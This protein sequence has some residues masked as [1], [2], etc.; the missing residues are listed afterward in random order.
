MLEVAKVFA[1]EAKPLR[2]VIFL[3]TTAHRAGLLG[4]RYYTTH[5]MVPQNTT[6]ANIYVDATDPHG[7]GKNLRTIGPSLHGLSEIVEV[8]GARQG[9]T[10]QIEHD[11]D[12]LFYFRL[13]Q[14]AFAEA[15]IPEIYLTTTVLQPPSSPGSPPTLVQGLPFNPTGALRDAELLYKI[16]SSVEEATNWPKFKKPGGGKRPAQTPAPTP[17]APPLQPR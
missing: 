8:I 16:V 1:R 12:R 11:P 15:G 7:D 5:P 9:R 13:S 2:S 14:T 4:L 3:V 10:L 6:R 17:G